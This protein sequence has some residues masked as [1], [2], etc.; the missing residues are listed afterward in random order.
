[1]MCVV[2]IDRESNNFYE[3]SLQIFF[4]EYC[5]VLLSF[6]KGSANRMIDDR[7]LVILVHILNLDVQM[8]K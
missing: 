4:L 3:V 2:N 7:H 1:M 6:R 8:L 5:N